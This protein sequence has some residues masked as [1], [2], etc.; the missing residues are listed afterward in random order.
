MNRVK[1]L[2]SQLCASST[3]AASPAEQDLA[4]GECMRA[5]K[6]AKYSDEEWNLRCK[7]AAAYRIADYYG[8]EQL[9]FNR[10]WLMLGVEVIWRRNA[11]CR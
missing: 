2:R 11:L 3:T 8:W 7:L 5:A 4:A 10:E 1:H 6:P 9:V